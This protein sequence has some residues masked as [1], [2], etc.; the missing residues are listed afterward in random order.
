MYLCDLH[1]EISHD[2]AQFL[3]TSHFFEATLVIQIVKNEHNKLK[4][5]CNQGKGIPTDSTQGF[6]WISLSYY[7]N[8]DEYE[9]INFEKLSSPQSDVTNST[10][11]LGV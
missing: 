9:S 6:I 10:Q 8:L 4:L 3:M 11:Y 1:F 2:Y 5:L 7:P